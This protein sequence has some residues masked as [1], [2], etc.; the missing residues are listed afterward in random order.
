MPMFGR[1]AQWIFL[2]DQWMILVKD[3]SKHKTDK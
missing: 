3:P 1:H 2:N